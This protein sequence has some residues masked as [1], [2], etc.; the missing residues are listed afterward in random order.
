MRQM[1]YTLIE[2]IVL[3][4]RKNFTRLVFP[5]QLHPLEPDRL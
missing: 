4:Y 2:G 3:N 1:V 5:V